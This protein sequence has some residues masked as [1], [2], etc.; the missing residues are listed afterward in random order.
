MD[1]LLN[2]PQ[3]KKDQY[4]QEIFKRNISKRIRQTFSKFLEERQAPSIWALPIDEENVLKLL[5]YCFPINP[6]IK[7]IIQRFYD[8]TGHRSLLLSSRFIFSMRNVPP[9]YFS[10]R[11]RFVVML[12]RFRNNE[13]K[14]E[15][16]K[17]LPL[18]QKNGQEHL[19]YLVIA[20]LV[21]DHYLDNLSS[22]HLLE[23]S[24]KYLNRSFLHLETSQGQLTLSTLLAFCL[25]MRRDFKSSI[26]CLQARRDN[27]LQAKFGELI[28]KVG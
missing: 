18:Y 14:E 28:R 25:Y 17:W 6:I 26:I 7:K 4:N 9:I 27:E 10:D 11:E 1:N 16:F 2:W 19:L 24:V 8:S 22:V 12:N 13:D 3:W 20:I 21:L 23:F 5:G 15:F